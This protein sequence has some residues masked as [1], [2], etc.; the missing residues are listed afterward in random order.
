MKTKDVVTLVVALV[1]LIAS[2]IFIYMQLFPSSE[3]SQNRVKPAD[4]I[5]EVNSDVLSDITYEEISNLNEYQKPPLEGL[6][7]ADLFAN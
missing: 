3:D 1:V 2:A 6:G 5:E 4:L 7:K